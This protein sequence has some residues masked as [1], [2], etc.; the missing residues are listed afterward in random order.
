LG[1]QDLAPKKQGQQRIFE[2]ATDWVLNQHDTAKFIQKASKH[3]H[4]TSTKPGLN[5]VF[6]SEAAPLFGFRPFNM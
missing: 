5:D 3:R 1:F 2:I 4:L 6:P